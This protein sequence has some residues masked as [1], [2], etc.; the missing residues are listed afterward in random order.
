MGMI[1]ENQILA[2][3]GGDKMLLKLVLKDYL[4][5][6]PKDIIEITQYSQE[7]NLKQM[8]AIAHRALSGTRILVIDQMI[9]LLEKIE[10]AEHIDVARE[11]L[12]EINALLPQLKNEIDGML[13]E[14]N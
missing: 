3:V 1:N 10:Y 4:G 5:S 2:N 9:E 13:R 7:E 12:E 14:S 6:F 8:K 11:G